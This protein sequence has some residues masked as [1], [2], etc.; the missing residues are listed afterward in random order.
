M[1]KSNISPVTD[2][3]PMGNFSARFLPGFTVMGKIGL[4][5]YQLIVQL[6]INVFVFKRRR[7]RFIT[8][9]TVRS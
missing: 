8:Q 2:S 7:L 5:S 6:I 9:A 4:E 1:T 3:C